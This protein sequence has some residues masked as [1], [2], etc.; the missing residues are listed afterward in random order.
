MAT[1]LFPFPGTDFA[2]ADAAINAEHIGSISVAQVSGSWRVLLFVESTS[3]TAVFQTEAEARALFLLWS[4]R[5]E[6]NTFT[7]ETNPVIVTPIFRPASATH[8]AVTVMPTSSLILAE[9]LDRRRIVLHNDSG[10]VVFIM[11]GPVCST[12][13]FSFRMTANET[14]LGIMGDYTG[15]ISAIRASGTSTLQVTE[16]VT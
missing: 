6:P 1:R 11:F 14:H 15:P 9:N 3:Y 4:E 12:T 13:A 5:A 16:I 8:A 10:S 7:T 2:T